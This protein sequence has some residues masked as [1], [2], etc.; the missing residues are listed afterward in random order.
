LNGYRIELE[1]IQ[2][3]ISKVPG[4]KN[5]KVL[6][7]V[8]DNET[9]L[10]AYVVKED[11]IYGNYKELTAEEQARPFYF[12]DGSMI[13]HQSD[14]QLA[15]LY[16]EIFEDAIYFKHQISVPENAMVFDVGANI[17]GFSIDVSQRHPGATII[18]FEPV[19]QIF[20][21]LRKNYEHRQ[22]KGRILNYGVSNKKETAT[23]HYYPDMSGMSGRFTEKETIISAVGKYVEYE[24]AAMANDAKYE[25][26]EDEKVIKSF[27]ET[28]D[29]K[30]DVSNE[31][32]NYL[33]SL[34]SSIEVECELTT[35][36]D[37]I[38]ELKID[39]IDLLK[40][41]AE[42]SEC[43]V[44]EGIRPEHW[45]MIHQVVIE[46]DGDH[47]LGIIEDLLGKKGYDVVVEELVMG[48][49]EMP[50]NDNTYM[51]YA[52]SENYIRKE[53]SNTAQI[54]ETPVFESSIRDFLRKMLPDYMIPKLISF[55]PSIPLMENGKVDMVKLKQVKP[56][57]IV[58]DSGNAKL[59]GKVELEVYRIWCEVLKKESIPHHV[60]IFEAGGN[61]IEVVLVH[62]KLQKEFNVEFS[63]I[64]LFR[65]PTISQQ[66]K[67]VQN[68]GNTEGE[69]IKT[70]ISKGASRRN[71]RAGRAD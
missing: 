9:Y 4:V 69:T 57:E 63:L 37:V 65:N 2:S 42:K 60:S 34:Y 8:K 28:L 14:R 51:L 17:G 46:V 45:A 39:S 5:C 36:S 26:G 71:V 48:D 62:N 6:P 1:E 44:L 54:F 58:A 24:K 68:A 33:T 20:S 7:I 16:R 61:S 67:L 22:I 27:Y 18:A 55:V 30:N 21:A 64:E 32:R 70:A 40:I 3:V 31:F 43:L 25:T 10:S 47:H 29:G 49:A 23:F 38:E 41:D 66:A 59:Y 15:A 56:Q 50:S 12:A 19:P 13:Y 52:K 11:I 35:I 53:N